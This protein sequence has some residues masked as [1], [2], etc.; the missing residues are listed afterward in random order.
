MPTMPLVI[1]SNIAL[2]LYVL[3]TSLGLIFV[4]LGTTDG[5]PIKLVDGRLSFNINFYVVSGIVLYA[6]SFLLYIY[7]I[8]RNDL[9][10]IIPVTTALVYT[11][12]FLGS[13]FIFHESFTATKVA[14]IALIMAGVILLNLQK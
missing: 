13:F 7:L 11:L 4:K 1:T 6:A 2:I 8:S 9:G 5:L 12:I 14:A 3:A 10:Y